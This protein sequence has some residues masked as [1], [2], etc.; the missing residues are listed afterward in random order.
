MPFRVISAV[1]TACSVFSD[2][3]FIFP[4]D[5]ITVS[6]EL[7]HEIDTF[8]PSPSGSVKSQDTLDVSPRSISG[9]L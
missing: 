6:S 4:S 8:V 9:T 3:L 5:V 2:V 7:L 1:S